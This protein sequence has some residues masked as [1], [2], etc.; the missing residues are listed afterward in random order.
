MSAQTFDE[1]IAGA[2]AALGSASRV[3]AITG[4][5]MSADS[6]MPTYRGVG[7]LYNRDDTADGV[8]IEQA[9]SGPMFARDPALTWKYIAQIEAA[10]RDARP[11]AGHYA[12]AALAECFDQF[13]VVTQNV[14]GLHRAA[15]SPQI[16]EMHGNI[17]R[18]FCICCGQSRDVDDFSALSECPPRCDRCGGIE[19]PAVVLFEEI[20]PQ[21]A[22]ERY[23]RTL[24]QGVDAVLLIGTTAVF[25]YIAAPVFEAAQ[26]GQPVIEINPQATTVSES[27]SVQCRARAADVLP[28]I[29]QR[30]HEQG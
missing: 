1:C 5:G 2:T 8:P 21:S 6:G 18:L 14:D 25:D 16:I 7:G 4:A 13:C 27:C 15:G 11:N 20:L 12:L 23:R 10:C 9:L 19:R 28:A 3:L 26:R 30:I 17:H 29:A 24:D 22:L